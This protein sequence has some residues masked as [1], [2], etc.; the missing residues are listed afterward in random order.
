MAGLRAASPSLN[1][2]TAKESQRCHQAGAALGAMAFLAASFEAALLGQV[3]AREDELRAAGRWDPAPSHLHLP[4]LAAL[5]RE[6][7]WLSESNLKGAR[8]TI[9]ELAMA[10]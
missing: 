8:S 4:E 2:L 7:G 3:I 9:W 1:L 10:N 6:M 5:G